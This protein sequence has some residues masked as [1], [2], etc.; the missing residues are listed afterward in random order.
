MLPHLSLILL[1]LFWPAA[2]GAAFRIY[3]PLTS[4][5]PSEHDAPAQGDARGGTECLLVAED[6]AQ[7][8][9][10]LQDNR[11]LVTVRLVQFMEETRAKMQE[12]G[13]EENAERMAQVLEKVKEMV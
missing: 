8:E 7:I 10:L 6:D 9:Q 2:G 13:E 12:E 11:D 1:L 4:R 5:P 3:L